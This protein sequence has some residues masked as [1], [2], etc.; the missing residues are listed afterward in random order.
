[1]STPADR[2]GVIHENYNS[3]LENEPHDLARATN[4]SDVT[5]IQA[6]VASARQTYYVAI[7]AALTQSG[8]AVEEAF[9]AAKRAQDAVKDARNTAAQIPTLISKLGQATKTATDLL[10][11]AKA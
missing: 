2:L 8:T 1:M 11:A 6:N 9:N 7:A 10:N 3:A 5:A 4:A